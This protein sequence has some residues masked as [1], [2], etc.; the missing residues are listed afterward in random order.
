MLSFLAPKWLWL[1]TFVPVLVAVYLLLLRRK[2][3]RNKQFGRTMLDF[4][5]PKEANWRRH[6]AVAFS[7]LSLI[8]LTLAIAKPKDTV[9][10]P[11]ERA[12]I[13]VTIDVSQLDGRHRRRAEPVAGGQD[14]GP[15]LRQLIAGQVQRLD[16]R[17]RGRGDRA[18]AAQPGP[19]RGGRGHL[20][21]A[22]GAVDGDR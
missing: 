14:G 15:G 9:E 17:V 18:V 13:V 16:R 5:I 21:H 11:R 6:V 19:R 1:L 7:I 12:T 20:Q 3:N 8:S 2:A 10:V 22:V 4:V